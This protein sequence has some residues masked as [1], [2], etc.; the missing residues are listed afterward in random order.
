M[1]ACRTI[2]SVR[3]F[4]DA[5]RGVSGLPCPES[6]QVSP[7]DERLYGEL[8]EPRRKSWLARA[9]VASGELKVVY[10]LRRAAALGRPYVSK[11]R[12]CG[13]KGTRVKCGCKGWR[14]VKPHTCRQHLLC[15]T[16]QRARSRRLGMR[17]RAGLEAA[18]SARPGE[19]LVLITLTLRHSGDVAL[20]RERL[21]EGWR[22]FTKAFWKTYGKFPYVGVW[23]VTPGDDGAGHMHMHVAV[24]WPW[25]N[26]SDVRGMWLDACPE[27]E[28]ISFVARR[29]DGRQSDPKSAANYLGKYLSKGLQTDEFSAELRTRVVA[30]TYNTRWVFT[31]RHF[32]LTFVP[33][34]QRCN[35]RIIG[36]QFRFR[37]E[38]YRPAIEL[39]ARGSP[40]LEFRF[41]ERAGLH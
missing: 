11:L 26:W 3:Q 1:G 31:S 13:V 4:G 38:P 36:A 17:I 5:A 10:A 2:A 40:Q 34:C 21:S 12:S 15:A 35:C 19:M 20:D 41:H 25:R 8:M 27:S 32:W 16:C 33:T 6:Q 37:G 23:E 7:L 29:R 18:L 9:A 30:G 39:D 14:G 24:V 28:R 22:K